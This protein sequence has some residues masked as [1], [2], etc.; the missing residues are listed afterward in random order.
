MTGSPATK[1]DIRGGRE[2]GVA[3]AAVEVAL[4]K[5]R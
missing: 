5:S 3:T 1:D 2:A 4:A